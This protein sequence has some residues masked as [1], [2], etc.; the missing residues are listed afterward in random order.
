MLRTMILHQQRLT[1]ET[2]PACVSEGRSQRIEQ[3]ILNP[4]VGKLSGVTRTRLPPNPPLPSALRE[5]FLSPVK[6]GEGRTT[7]WLFIGFG[8][9]FRYPVSPQ[10]VFA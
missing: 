4:A 6:S 1:D 5:V 8:V 10:R 9:S 3:L 7:S 2:L